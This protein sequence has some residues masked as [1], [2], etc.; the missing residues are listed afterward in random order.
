ML[1]AGQKLG[2]YR[3]QQRLSTS[4]FAVV[5]KAFDT[6]EGGSVALKMPHPQLTDAQF[7]DEFRKEVRLAVKLDHGNILSVKNANFIDG[8]FVI[9]LPLGDCTLADRL[10]SRMSPKTAI[11]FTEQMLV[12]VAHAHERKVIHCDLKPENLIIFNGEQL[13]LADFGIAKMA[14]RTVRASG[15]GT[16]GYVAPEQAMGRPSRRSDVFSLGLILYRLFSGRLPE[17]P[18]DW[19]PP[20]YDKLRRRVSPE[21]I[22]FLERALQLNPAKRYRDA[23]QMLTE[24]RRI[25]PYV[26][27]RAPARERV[28]PGNGSDAHE[29][30]FKEFQRGYRR[31]LATRHSCPACDG[32]VSEAMRGCPWCGQSL[33]VHRGDTDFPAHCPRCKRGAKLDWRF[34]AWCYGAG[35]APT[36][37]RRYSDKRYAARCHRARCRGSLMPFMRYCPWCRAKVQRKWKVPGAKGRCS[38]CGWGVVKGFW[39][40]CPWCVKQL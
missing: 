34:C 19:P 31:V 39:K 38:G 22:R 10:K 8:H 33:E 32:P 24:F 4:A 1:K 5:Y 11:S 16:V 35:F 25:K 21:F 18:Y 40:H 23:G 26:L 15:S 7:I 2:K 9:V 36:G 3:I 37:K 27:R 30:R 17:W 6:I 29:A 14:W 13:R 20:G 12:A 28:V